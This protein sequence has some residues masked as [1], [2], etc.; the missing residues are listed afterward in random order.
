MICS[1]LTNHDIFLNL[2]QQLLIARWWGLIILRI[3]FR[4]WR[5]SKGPWRRKIFYSSYRAEEII[6]K[7]TKSVLV[8]VSIKYFT[9]QSLGKI[10]FGTKWSVRFLQR[11]LSL[12][13]FSM[14]LLNDWA[15][16]WYTHTTTVCE[17][18]FRVVIFHHFFQSTRRNESKLRLK[19][20]ITVLFWTCHEFCQVIIQ[21][22][23]TFVSLSQTEN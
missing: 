4:F 13:N 12:K 11:Q 2:V 19:A 17:E 9:S 20:F 21:I 8:L 15:C 14:S 10:N 18:H 6:L 1:P 16:Y 22:Q 5:R 23:S 3:I 7:E